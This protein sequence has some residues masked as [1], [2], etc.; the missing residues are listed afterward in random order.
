[1]MGRH[2]IGYEVQKVLALVDPRTRPS[3]LAR[4]RS[5]P[6]SLSAPCL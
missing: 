6:I 3:D 5:S 2:L 4:P 1:M